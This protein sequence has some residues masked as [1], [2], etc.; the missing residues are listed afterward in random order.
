MTEEIASFPDPSPGGSESSGL[1][2][3]TPAGAGD[4]VVFAETARV[5]QSL[6]QGLAG[7]VLGAADAIEVAVVAALTGQHLLIEDVPGVGKTVLARA[8]ATALGVRLSR[9]QGHPDLLPS[10]VTGVTIYS[11][12]TQSWEFRPGPVFGHVIL[13]DEMNRTPPRTQ[14]A[15]LEAMEERQVTVD[16]ESWALPQ[17]HLVIGTQNPL[18]QLGTYPLAESQL[19]RFGLSTS[20]GYPDAPTEAQLVIHHGGRTALAELVPVTDP[21][22][23]ERTIAST[24]T[25]GVSAVVAEYAV[26]LVRASRSLSGVRLGASPRAAIT[27]ISAAQGAAVLAGRPYVTPDDVQKMAA[28]VLAH[29]LLTDDGHGD[30]AVRRLLVETPP[31]VA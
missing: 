13:L 19:D 9:V 28:P 1:V 4:S 8:L 21:L 29:R 27:L 26:A 5:A 30:Q 2:P 10:D 18:G 25:V 15:L 23:W 24:A 11:P 7:V 20:I 14:S 3:G 22:G 17:P 31:P 12:A 16:G 6:R